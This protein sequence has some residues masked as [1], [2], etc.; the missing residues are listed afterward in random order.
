MLSWFLANDILR[1]DSRLMTA[2]NI[3]RIAASQT[4]IDSLKTSRR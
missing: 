2:R 1:F 3:L 4:E